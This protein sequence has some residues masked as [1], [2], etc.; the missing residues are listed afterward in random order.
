P[1]A[2]A[3]MTMIGGRDR[4]TFTSIRPPCDVS[5]TGPMRRS[6][7]IRVAYPGSTYE[8]LALIKRRYDPANVFH[9]NQNIRPA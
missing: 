9:R 6:A 2:M 8:R 3:T 5:V 7:R 4:L 1:R